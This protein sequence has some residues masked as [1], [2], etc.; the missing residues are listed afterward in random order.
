MKHELMHTQNQKRFFST[1]AQPSEPKTTKENTSFI[2]YD[3]SYMRIKEIKQV[4][5]ADIIE[6]SRTSIPEPTKKNDMPLIGYF[7]GFCVF[8]FPF[9]T[10]IIFFIL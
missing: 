4:K 5:S 2:D 1:Q 7:A 8:C 6:P 3:G 10:L 9:T